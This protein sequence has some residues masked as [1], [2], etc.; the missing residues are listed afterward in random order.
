PRT[1]VVW[2]TATPA[3][4]V[5]AFRGPVGIT[6]TLIPRSRA[7]GR[8]VCAVR[9]VENKPKTKRIRMIADYTH[10]N[11]PEAM[12][13]AKWLNDWSDGKCTNVM[14]LAEVRYWERSWVVSDS[15]SPFES[16]R[17][18]QRCQLMPRPHGSQLGSFEI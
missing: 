16:L 17:Q 5:M 8:T 9:I 14:R 13:C 12:V 10:D 4:S 6:P 15:E 3:T 1:T 18:S 7:L 2:P 11:E